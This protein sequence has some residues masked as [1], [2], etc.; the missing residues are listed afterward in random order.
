MRNEVI[1]Q[2]AKARGVRLYE[3]AERLGVSPSEFSM[4]FT[5]KP[6]SETENASLRAI[7]DIIAERREEHETA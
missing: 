4:R 1:K 7:I 6:L 2:Y 5:R 3:V